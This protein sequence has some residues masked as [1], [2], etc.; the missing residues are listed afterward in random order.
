VRRRTP[1]MFMRKETNEM[2]VRIDRG[3]HEIARAA[4]TAALNSS[5]NA[6][7]VDRRSAN[8]RR[9]KRC[10]LRKHPSRH[11]SSAALSTLRLFG[12]SSETYFCSPIPPRAV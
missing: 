1:A 11:H 5:R 6:R 8:R 12:A 4:I 10:W 3:S 2:L 7:V 9:R